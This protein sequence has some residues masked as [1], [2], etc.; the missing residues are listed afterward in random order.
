V[1]SVTLERDVLAT[2]DAIVAAQ[3]TSRSAV[4]EGLV[5]EEQRRQRRQR[6]VTK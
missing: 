6:R 1:V 2:L 3:G 5:L 4:V